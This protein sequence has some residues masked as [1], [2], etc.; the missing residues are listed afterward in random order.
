MDL[1]LIPVVSTL[2]FSIMSLQTIFFSGIYKSLAITAFSNPVHYQGNSPEYYLYLQ[3][4]PMCIRG[5][6]FA[7]SEAE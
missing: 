7:I 3:T 6:Q 1:I 4:R 2:V 5:L